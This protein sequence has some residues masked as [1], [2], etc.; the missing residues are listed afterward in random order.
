MNIEK[1]MSIHIN[2]AP[3]EKGCVEKAIESKAARV[4]LQLE[5]IKQ[6]REALCTQR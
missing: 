3:I 2:A 6:K 1:L 4:R 5:E